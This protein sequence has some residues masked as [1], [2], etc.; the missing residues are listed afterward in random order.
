MEVNERTAPIREMRADARA[1]RRQSREGQVPLAEQQRRAR[2]QERTLRDAGVQIMHQHLVAPV[3]E[4]APAAAQPVINQAQANV[5]K[6]HDSLRREV[7]PNSNRDSGP[8]PTR[9]PNYNPHGRGVGWKEMPGPGYVEPSAAHLRAHDIVSAECEKSGV[10]PSQEEFERRIH[11]AKESFNSSSHQQDKVVYGFLS[12][13]SNSAHNSIDN[14]ARDAFLSP[15]PAPFSAKKEVV[16][17]PRVDVAQKEEDRASMLH[18]SEQSDKS[19]SARL[20]GIKRDKDR[21]IAQQEAE[22]LSRPAAA[23]RPVDITPIIRQHEHAASKHVPT[24]EILALPAPTAVAT[25]TKS[26]MDASENKRQQLIHRA[27]REARFNMSMN[28]EQS[29]K[30]VNVRKDMEAN[31]KAQGIVRRAPRRR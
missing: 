6:L 28:A 20:L 11:N 2:Q 14:H 25:F 4:V 7:T 15:T 13:G 26:H 10:M 19:L 22:S 24:P 23:P 30:V 3:I 27:E 29:M 5:D 9:L 18:A 17:A 16:I 1:V 21:K 12:G 31:E 8:I